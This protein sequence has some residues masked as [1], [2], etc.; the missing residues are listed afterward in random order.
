M[1]VPTV[2]SSQA[3]LPIL[4]SFGSNIEPLAN[5][6]HGLR[7]LHQEIGL[8]AV[9]TVYRT[10]ALAEPDCPESAE[11]DAEFLNGA[12]WVESDMEPFSLRR[13]LRDIEGEL[14]RV[15]TQRSYAPR[16]LDLDIAVMGEQV[17]NA[18]PLVIPDPDIVHRS[19]LAIPLAELAP[20]LL[21]PLKKVSLS[22]IAARFGPHPQGL[23][24]DHQATNLLQGIPQQKFL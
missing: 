1:L 12:V 8:C 17:I 3:G 9:S 14:H 10:P 2:A 11:K 19:F 6:F 15:R 13:L 4:I 21:H 7:R 18:A 20:D 24:M 22:H 23:T 16:T 5:L